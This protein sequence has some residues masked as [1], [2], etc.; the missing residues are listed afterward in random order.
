MLA[1]VVWSTDVMAT[2]E[3][4]DEIICEYFDSPELQPWRIESLSR[5]YY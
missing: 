3:P 2:V 1:A 4:V 5:G